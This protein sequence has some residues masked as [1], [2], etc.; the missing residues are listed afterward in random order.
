M[1][2]PVVS[3]LVDTFNHEAFIEQAIESVLRQDFPVSQREIVAVDD[4]STDR[5]PEILRRFAPEVRLLCKK[6]G[7]QASAFNLGIPECRGEIIA[8][9]DGDDWWVPGK[10][11]RVVELLASDKSAGIVGHAILESFGDGSERVVAPEKAERLHLDSLAAARVFRLRKSYLG[12]SRM[13]LRAELARRIL[14]VPEALVLEADEYVFTLAA[15]L[16]DAVILPEPLTHYRI[17]AGNLYLGAGASPAA[18]RRKLGVHDAL[19]QALRRNLPLC[20]TP[21]G[22]VDCITEIVSAEADQMRL[23]LDGGAPWQ[24]V[25]TERSIYRVL[26]GDASWS[27]RAFREATMLPAWILPPKWFYAARRWVAARPWYGRVRR[28]VLPVPG[29]T[30][31]AGPGEF[32]A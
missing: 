17:H 2:Q 11:R 16:S 18:T 13:A 14:P 29:M 25:R 15:A 32:K 23:A 8:F 27:H 28:N 22:A 9:L 3:V 12:T 30:R 1:T 10:L 31:V 5:T 4:G 19:A 24:T 21:P 6:N 26:H 7:G 20:G